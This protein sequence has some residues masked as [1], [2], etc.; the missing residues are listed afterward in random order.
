[1]IYLLGLFLSF[2]A[3]ARTQA[4]FNADKAT[5]LILSMTAGDDDAGRL[6]QSLAAPEEV[7]NGKRTKKF[8]FEEQLTF[9]CVLSQFVEGNGTCTVNIH[10]GANVSLGSGTAQ[11]LTTDENQ[12]AVLRQLFAIGSFSTSDGHFK[13]VSQPESLEINYR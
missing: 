2:P 3:D 4:I 11:F 12:L 13:I 6:Y 5:V 8:K 10:R 1:M 9:V 7:I